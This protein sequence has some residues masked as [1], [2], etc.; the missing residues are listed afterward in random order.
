MLTKTQ[1]LQRIVREYQRDGQKWPATAA[2]IANWA[3][4]TGRNELTTPTV[5]RHVARE[6]AQAM[7]EEYFTDAQGRRVRAKHPARVAKNGQQLMLWDDIR[8][9]PRNHMQMAFQLRRRR[10]A[11]ECK[12]VKTDVD[13]YNNTHPDETPIQMVLD[14]TQ[15]VEEIELAE[16]SNKPSRDYLPQ[17]K[18]PTKTVLATV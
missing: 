6:L 11:A 14:F 2:E 7:R 1:Q 12:Q 13:S 17:S 3:V 8:S 16:A 5:E 15:D 9:A 18:R 10:I 4:N